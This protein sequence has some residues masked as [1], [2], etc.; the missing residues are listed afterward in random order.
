MSGGMPVYRKQGDSDKWLMYNPNAKDWFVQS[1]SSK[2]T[3]SGYA[4]LTCDP[5]CLPENGTKHTWKVHD[6]SWSIQAGVDISIFDNL[7]ND[8]IYY[9][10][11][12]RYIEIASNSDTN[13]LKL[14]RVFVKRVGG[15]L[16]ENAVYL[17]PVK[18]KRAPNLVMNCP[19]AKIVNL[20]FIPLFSELPPRDSQLLKVLGQR[21]RVH[22]DLGRNEEI[23]YI[24]VEM[25]GHDAQ[26][27]CISIR[28][29]YFID[30]IASEG[31]SPGLIIP[32]D[33]QHVIR[34][35]IYLNVYKFCLS[36]ICKRKIPPGLAQLTDR[37]KVKLRF[38]KYNN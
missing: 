8:K 5:P 35:G 20:N 30:L 32:F 36:S 28:D 11:A 3:S 37:S 2:G 21:P 33:S 9:Y 26:V 1:T 18:T 19:E 27:R 38:K 13:E 14:G 12:A 15:E 34:N 22:I 6:G 24:V 23:E 10:P 7:E 29:K 4:Y 25:P 31:S 17:K 16:L